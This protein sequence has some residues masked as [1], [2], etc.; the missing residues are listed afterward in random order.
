LVR[1]QLM[2]ETYLSLE[3]AFMVENDIA[4]GKHEIFSLAFFQYL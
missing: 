1:V 3:P 2:K 4:D